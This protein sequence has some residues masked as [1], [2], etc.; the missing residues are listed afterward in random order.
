MEF[1]NITFSCSHKNV[2]CNTL[3]ITHLY[4]IRVSLEQQHSNA[5]S[6]ITLDHRYEQS[7]CVSESE[8]RRVALDIY[9]QACT[10][11]PDSVILGLALA[12][13][14]ELRKVSDNDE[15]ADPEAVFER[16]WKDAPCALVF[17]EHQR[18]ARRLSGVKASRRVFRRARKHEKCTWQVFVSA[19]RLEYHCNNQSDAARNIL[20]LGMKRYSVV[21]DYVLAYA[22]LLS[23]MNDNNNLRALFERTI[24]TLMEQKD[25]DAAMR[26]WDRYVRFEAQESKNGGNIKTME[27]VMRRWREAMPDVDG[28]KSLRAST[29]RYRFLGLVPNENYVDN[30]FVTHC[31]SLPF[32]K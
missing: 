19:A 2:N 14:E 32:E 10:A 25:R 15:D 20:E 30:F 21:M 16:L 23:C 1:E 12:E 26:V 17:V 22:D 31:P 11:M 18:V 24:P 4:I 28:L 7:V 6:N 13:I 3:C 29:Y 8:G 27:R 5:H 9:R